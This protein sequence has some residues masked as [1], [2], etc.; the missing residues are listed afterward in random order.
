MKRIVLLILR[1]RKWLYEFFRKYLP[2]PVRRFLRTTIFKTGPNPFPLSEI[3]AISSLPA[4]LR[5]EVYDVIVFPII[6]WE[7]R[8]QRP[9]QI[10]TQFAE[11]GHRVF[12]LRPAFSR[13]R[14][15]GYRII[16]GSIYE[17]DL[18][19]PSATNI[20]SDRIDEPMMKNIHHGF[21]VLRR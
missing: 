18:P 4:A 16:T 14:N 9:Q 5:P 8:F 20:Y 13:R 12:Y 1:I 15:P 17:V 6:D 21:D 3:T 2:R 10:A 19:G 7:F 11:A